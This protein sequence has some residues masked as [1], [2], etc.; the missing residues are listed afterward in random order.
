MSV[1]FE[2]FPRI[3]DPRALKP[4]RWFMAPSPLGPI[5]CLLTEVVVEDKPVVLTFGLGK[6]DSLEVRSTRLPA[7]TGPLTTIEDDLVFTPGED[8]QKLRLLAATKRPFPNGALLRL[9][10]GDMGMGFAETL[11]GDLMII[12][13][14]SGMRVVGF[15]LIFDRWSLSLRRGP[16]VALV[17]HFKGPDRRG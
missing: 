8:A 10:N 11:G 7:I 5:V 2:G 17:G 4:G 9:S 6:I 14:A 13:L 15:D 3:L 1:Y 16:T 12:S